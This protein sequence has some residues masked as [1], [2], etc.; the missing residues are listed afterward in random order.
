MEGTMSNRR[1]G[2]RIT[3]PLETGE[4]RPLSDASKLLWERYWGPMNAAAT[5]LNLALN[6]AQ[7]ILGALILEKEGVDPE[8]FSV[9][10]DKMRIVPRPRNI[11]AN[12]G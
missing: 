5:Q 12:G 6:N 8:K 2:N 4:I 9:D 11:G 10:V 1:I 3:P 7:N